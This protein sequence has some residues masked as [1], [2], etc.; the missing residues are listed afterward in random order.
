ML[1]LT[2]ATMALCL[3][4]GSASADW[5]TGREDDTCGISMEY[6]GDGSTQL[7]ILGTGINE[8][9]IQITNYNWSAKH[10]E[11]YDLQYHMGNHYYE[12][13]SAGI[14]ASDNRKGFVTYL[15][16]SFIIDFAKSSGLTLKIG[17][18]LVDDLSLAGSGAAIA[19]FNACRRAVKAEIAKA[20]ADEERLKY[21]PKDPFAN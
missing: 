17:D 3:A 19:R 5:V 20:K 8:P 1:K 15:S 14:E 4:A 10:G 9:L 6:E 18:K 21:I 12:I 7:M 11:R 16:A 13:P 2:C